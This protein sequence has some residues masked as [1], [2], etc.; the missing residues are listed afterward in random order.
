MLRPLPNQWAGSRGVARDCPSIPDRAPCRAHRLSI[1]PPAPC[2]S[3]FDSYS[4]RMTGPDVRGFYGALGVQ[5][6]AW[7]TRE[8][9]VRCF[10]DADA[11]NRADRTPSCSVN[12][13]SGAWNCHGCGARGGACDAALATGHTP[14]SAMQL[15]FVH[16]L[17]EP[18]SPNGRAA[19]GPT[20][21]VRTLERQRS[22]PRSRVYSV[23]A[24]DE[25]DIRFWAERLNVNKSLS[26]RLAT[27]RA[28]DPRVNRDLE[29]GFDGTRI[30]VPIRN[31]HGALR[32][33]LRYDPFGRR[34]PKMLRHPRNTTRSDP[35]PGAGGV[36]SGRPR[37]GT[38]RHGRGA[39]VRPARDRHPGHDR[40]A[41]VVSPAA[42]G[43][44]CHRPDGLRR[45]RPPRRRRG[46]DELR[47]ADVLADPV[48][49][50]PDRSDG[51]DLTDRILERRRMRAGSLATRTIASLLRPVP[52]VHRNRARPRARSNQEVAR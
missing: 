15:L 43:S 11:H 28:W 47:A 31:Q 52:P 24:A 9:P 12:L 49:L 51:Y 42:R 14:R 38:A 5:L 21:R 3:S 20:T 27:E 19:D 41:A 32:G 46:R 23:L 25:G 2:P 44:A 18:R 36:E 16:D 8:A 50:W 45:R 35:A 17:A 6:P 37:R 48:D 39:L 40:L 13:T 1:Y 34:A 29:L 7:A 33:M 4:L 10:A 22:R 30:T 26:L